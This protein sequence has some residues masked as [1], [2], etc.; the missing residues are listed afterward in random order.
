MKKIVGII[1]L[2]CSVKN[3]AM[4]PSVSGYKMHDQAPPE[5]TY[6]RLL[7]KDLWQ[8]LDRFNI[9]D[10]AKEIVDKMMTKKAEFTEH[11][12]KYSPWIIS[13]ALLKELEPFMSRHPFK[14]PAAMVVLIKKVL[15]QL[16]LNFFPYGSH[17]KMPGGEM[18]TIL[19]ILGINTPRALEWLKA[20]IQQDPKLKG[21]AE[22]LLSQI[23]SFIWPG[24][25][26]ESTAI[27]LPS[28]EQKKSVVDI[29]VSAGI[30]I[31]YA[32]AHIPS[33][34]AL[35]DAIY[36]G[37]PLALVQHLIKRGARLIPSS[38]ASAEE[39]LNRAQELADEEKIKS[40]EEVLSFIRKEMKR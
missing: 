3:Y 16:K 22:Y 39:R 2:L 34:T 36:R 13:S 24:Y 7:P 29:F 11:Q 31:N 37:A 9:D 32:P 40:S 8:E 35:N 10:I 5:G 33:A 28:L 27:V 21:A 30:D 6:L 18:A 23:G 15:D 12:L 1:I 25:F 14:T 38:L 20:A 19:S 26:D 17:I 4:E